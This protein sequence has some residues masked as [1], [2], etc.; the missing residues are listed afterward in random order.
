MHIYACMYGNILLHIDMYIST[1]ADSS[2]DAEAGIGR[3]SFGRRALRSAGKQ[4]IYAQ[5]VH[6]QGKRAH[7]QGELIRG[8]GVSP[9]RFK[10]G[11]VTRNKPHPRPW[12]VPSCMHNAENP[13]I[14]HLCMHGNI[15]LHVDIYIGG[16]RFLF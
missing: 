12:P 3:G 9:G 6:I 4:F 15:S 13:F 5:T 11:L 10:R 7:T 2:L 14:L 16:G 8:C 1:A